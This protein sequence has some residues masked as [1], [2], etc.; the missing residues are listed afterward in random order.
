MVD[1]SV[2]VAGCLLK[3]ILVVMTQMDLEDKKFQFFKF[4]KNDFV[5]ALNE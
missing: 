4:A 3:A 2:L 1:M 5:K